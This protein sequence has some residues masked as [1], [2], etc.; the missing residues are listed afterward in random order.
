M[1]PTINDIAE[2]RKRA[3]VKQLQMQENGEKPEIPVDEGEP[4][5]AKQEEEETNDLDII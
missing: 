4:A 5:E 3:F 1:R 2:A